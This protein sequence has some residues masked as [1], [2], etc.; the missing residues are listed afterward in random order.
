MAHVIGGFA[1]RG[2]ERDVATEAF[3]VLGVHDNICL[4]VV[5]AEAF[6]VLDQ[7]FGPAGKV[8]GEGRDRCIRDGLESGAQG[9]VVDCV[10]LAVELN[11]DLPL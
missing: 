10:D 4:E 11:V 2:L 5:T 8:E 7:A 1:T 9:A 6:A 3:A